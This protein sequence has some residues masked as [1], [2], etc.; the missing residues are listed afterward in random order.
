MVYIMMKGTVALVAAN[1]GFREFFQTKGY[2]PSLRV[3][4]SHLVIAPDGVSEVQNG[5]TELTNKYMNLSNPDS[6]FKFSQGIRSHVW[7]QYL[8]HFTIEHFVLFFSTE[9]KRILQEVLCYP[10][11]DSIDEKWRLAFNQMGDHALLKL[12]K[13][14]DGGPT[15][16]SSG[17]KHLARLFPKRVLPLLINTKT[18]KAKDIIDARM[19]GVEV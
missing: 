14:F 2:K 7:E 5:Y 13:K 10:V 11:V 1:K 4:S 18:L 15:W 6:Y 19:R 8:N 12:Y 17:I 16:N 3:N 9:G